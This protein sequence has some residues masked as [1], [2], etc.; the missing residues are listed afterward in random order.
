MKLN[1]EKKS[2]EEFDRLNE[3]LFESAAQANK[4]GNMMWTGRSE[5]SVTHSLY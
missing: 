2:E 4:Y 5:I 3:A 1:H